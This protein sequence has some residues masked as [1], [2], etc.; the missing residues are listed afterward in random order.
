MIKLHLMVTI[1]YSISSFYTCLVTYV[2]CQCFNNYSLEI[3]FSRILPEMVASILSDSSNREKVL[4][5]HDASEVLRDAL[6]QTEAFMNHH[7]E[8][9]FPSNYFPLFIFMFLMHFLWWLCIVYIFLFVFYFLKI[10]LV[11][12]NGM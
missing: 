9:F 11:I 10:F 7:Y 2:S 5:Q 8:V 6:S 3:I 1:F 4:S 12:V